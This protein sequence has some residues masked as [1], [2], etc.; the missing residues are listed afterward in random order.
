MHRTTPTTPWCAL[1]VQGM[2]QHK[3]QNA[4]ESFGNSRGDHT[5]LSG[6]D[7]F[8]HESTKSIAIELG[9]SVTQSVTRCL[10]EQVEKR[11]S[12]G[13]FMFIDSHRWSSMVAL[14]NKPWKYSKSLKHQTSKTQNHQTPSWIISKFL[15]LGIDVFWCVLMLY[16]VVNLLCILTVYMCVCA[17]TPVVVYSLYMSISHVPMQASSCLQFLVCCHALSSNTRFSGMDEVAQS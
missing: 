2:G 16:D 1:A 10:H 3:D 8:R 11:A 12:L 14:A 17:I 4:L 9:Q 15:R 7:F 6:V 13:S 5:H